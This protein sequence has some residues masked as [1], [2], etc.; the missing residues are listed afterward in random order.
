MQGDFGIVVFANGADLGGGVFDNF[1]R[2][3][4]A[5]NIINDFTFEGINITGTGDAQLLVDIQTN[6]INRNGP[7]VN[8]DVQN[9][10]T[11]A[12]PSTMSLLPRKSSFTLVSNLTH[13]TQV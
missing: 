7:G 9:N 3:N 2:I 12:V 10:D 6:Q 5:D 8:N 11:F 13:S 4:I 1:T